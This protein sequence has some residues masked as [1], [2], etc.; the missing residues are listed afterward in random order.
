MIM[1]HVI[2][3]RKGSRR[4]ELYKLILN[5]RWMLIRWKSGKAYFID[6]LTGD[7]VPQELRKVLLKAEKEIFREKIDIIGR[8]SN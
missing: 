2:S 4:G 5:N 8:E 7:N 1:E 6:L 3:Y